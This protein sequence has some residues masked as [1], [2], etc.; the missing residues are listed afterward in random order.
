MGEGRIDGSITVKK[1]PTGEEEASTPY[2][3]ILMNYEE[4][5]EKAISEQ[6]IPLEYK[7]H[8]KK[9]FEELK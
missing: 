1:A 8:I 5:A 6:M 2:S 3:E 7:K 9:Y 4:A